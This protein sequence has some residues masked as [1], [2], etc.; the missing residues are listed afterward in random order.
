MTLTDSRGI[1]ESRRFV[2]V[3]AAMLAG[4]SHCGA[5]SDH[6]QAGWLEGPA[7]AAPD[8]GAA[9]GVR[10][11]GPD[12]RPPAGGWPPLAPEEPPI[13][14]TLGPRPA[15][16]PGPA[17]SPEPAP[18]WIKDICADS[19]PHVASA[20]GEYYSFDTESR[21]T[22]A[23][24]ALEPP[25]ADAAFL[26]D[27]GPG[28]WGPTD[29][30]GDGA[31]DQVMR[32]TTIDFWS[33]LFFL[34]RGDCLRYAGLLEGFQIELTRTKGGAVRARVHTYPIG[35]NSRVDPYVWDGSSFQLAAQ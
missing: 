10:G 7:R 12:R 14:L 3:L 33:H 13:V 5:A 18:P 2:V 27:V 35:P 23:E 11:A 19:R 21:A 28:Y 24:L 20:L 25:T 31:D 16:E 29:I 15:P 8:G 30:D 17:D 22:L 4:L 26:A 32:F 6:S 9:V 34:R 1:A